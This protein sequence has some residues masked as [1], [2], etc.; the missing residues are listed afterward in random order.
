MDHRI[1]RPSEGESSGNYQC[2]RVEGNAAGSSSKLERLRR[3]HH[4]SLETRPVTTQSQELRELQQIISNIDTS[5][6]LDNPFYEENRLLH[7]PSDKTDVP[8]QVM[9]TDHDSSAEL[10]EGSESTIPPRCSKRKRGADIA[11]S[12]WASEPTPCLT[13][14]VQSKD[15]D[16]FNALEAYGIIPT[17]SSTARDDTHLQQGTLRNIRQQDETVQQQD[18]MLQQYEAHDQAGPSDQAEAVFA[19]QRNWTTE[20]LNRLVDDILK[21]ESFNRKTIH[22]DLTSESKAIW[23]LLNRQDEHRKSLSDQEW[24]D[25]R[26]RFNVHGLNNKHERC[27]YL[28]SR[29]ERERKRVKASKRKYVQS[30]AGKASKRKYEQSD[31]R[32]VS[33]RKYERSDAGKAAR[34]R[35]LEKK[36]QREN[37]ASHLELTWNERN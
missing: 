16:L 17:L 25:I 37:S 9:Q 3:E 15:R 27:R 6:F 7:T 10:A 1:T 33:R 2:Q 23:E 26:N 31:A 32:K 11:P 14:T 5:E 29:T 24:Y 22:Q 13:E 20:Q 28:F 34:R 19:Q 4:F 30:D 18:A 36:N 21:I 12:G 8:V 35:Y